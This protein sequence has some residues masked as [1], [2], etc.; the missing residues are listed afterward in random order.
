MF[1]EKFSL[2]SNKLTGKWKAVLKKDWPDQERPF[3]IIKQGSLPFSPS[4]KKYPDRIVKRHQ[5]EMT[6]AFF[7]PEGR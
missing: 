7:M 2:T 1:V 4:S 5:S 3:F 6:G